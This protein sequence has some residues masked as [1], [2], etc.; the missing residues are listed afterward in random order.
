MPARGA[1][2][3]RRSVLAAAG[4]LAALLLAEPARAVDRADGDA[5]V[6]IM[7]LG[8]SLTAGTG[9]TDGAGWRGHLY[10]RLTELTSVDFVGSVSSGGSFDP[11]HEG[12]AGLRVGQAADAVPGWLRAAEPELVLLQLGTNDLKIAGREVGATDRLARLLDAI[13]AGAPD[14]YLVVG[15]MIGSP[16]AP[17]RE[18]MAA[19][20]A[21]LPG[22]VAPLADR[23]QLVDL[24]V[25]DRTA[26]FADN[27]HPN[28]PGY[29]VLAD[30][31]Y[32]A[33]A[34]LLS[35]R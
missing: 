30:R 2:L 23:A 4:G 3:T 15:S 19:F 21:A 16:A 13:A 31:W 28:D 17:I 6:R 12:H 32:A 34:P 14:A 10:S 7:P 24:D 26:H 20:N 22:L 35:P 5:P 18:R 25:L 8:D 27:L 9:S 29:A 33:V 11:E 1:G